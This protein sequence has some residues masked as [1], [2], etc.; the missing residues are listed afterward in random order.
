MKIIATS[1]LHGDLP[2]TPECDL[3]IVAGDICPIEGHHD[4]SSQAFWLVTQFRPWLLS[5]PAKNK[6]FIAGNHDYVFQSEGFAIDNPYKFG[7]Y[8]LQDS[9]VTIDGVKVWGMPWVPNL[10]DWAFHASDDL[11]VEKYSQIPDD[12]DI[13][14]SHG[15][16]NGILD[17][18]HRNENVGAKVSKDN[19]S[20][21]ALFVS[22]HIHESYGFEIHRTG[23]SSDTV[24]VNASRMTE[25]YDPV[26]DFVEIHLH[27]ENNEWKAFPMGCNS[28][29]NTRGCNSMVESQAFNLLVVGSS[30]TAPMNTTQRRDNE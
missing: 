17:K 26:N 14:I 12:A 10:P 5:Q 4:I 24:F 21:A 7:G 30:P 3:L 11:L 13:V 29:C 6:V 19:L 8:Y 23:N 18:T 28:G 15:P 2:E 16:V 25:N 9:A 20:P 1:D 22:G 27:K